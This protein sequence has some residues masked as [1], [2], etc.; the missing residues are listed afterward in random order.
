MM[1]GAVARSVSP[2]MA[3]NSILRTDLISFVR[4]VFGTVSPGDGFSP[5]WHLEAMCHQ[6]SK[7]TRRET[8]RLVITIPPGT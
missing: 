7:V 4:K 2:Q 5:N 6:L 1:R 8:R 3:L